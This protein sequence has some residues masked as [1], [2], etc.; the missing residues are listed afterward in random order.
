MRFA[1]TDEQIALRDAVRDVLGEASPSLGGRTPGLGWAGGDDAAVDRVWGVLVELGM[2]GMAVPERY[3]GL[4][5]SDVDLVPVLIEVGA[6]AVPLPVA[7]TAAVAAPLLSAAGD[8]GGLLPGIVAGTGRIALRLGAGPVPYAGRSDLVLDLAG[9]VARIGPPAGADLSTVDGSRAARTV[10]PGGGAVVTT[11]PD[12]IAHARDRA[13]VATAAQL[14]GLSRR[15]LDMTVAYVRSRHQFGVAVG[16][17]QA[18]KHWL[19]DALRHIEF[20]EPVVLAAAW[21]SSTGSPDRGRD[22][23]A[24]V[25]LAVDAA[26]FVARAAIQCHGAMAYTVE[27]D[28]HLYAKRAWA[29][30]ATCDLDAHLDRIAGALDLPSE[31]VLA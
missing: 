19:A 6:A 17:Y 18:V 23:S 29:L 26:R 22:V 12:L 21:A 13:A 7:E 11:D 10:P 25:I 4:G 31:G 24:A 30:A 5:L 1:L 8:P 16:S 2:P 20:A 3:G 9:P 28:L 27:Y 15:M 14:V